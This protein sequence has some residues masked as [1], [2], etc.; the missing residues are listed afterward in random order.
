MSPERQVSRLQWKCAN[1]RTDSS[2]EHANDTAKMRMGT[3]SAIT[4]SDSEGAVSGMTQSSESMRPQ[5]RVPL[6]FFPQ[7]SAVLGIHNFGISNSNLWNSRFQALELRRASWGPSVPLNKSL[8]NTGFPPSTSR[9]QCRNHLM[10]TPL[11]LQAVN[12][13]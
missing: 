9:S 2:K 7:S 5:S 1:I 10:R 8:K 6:T 4:V 13:A 11:Q 12:L 3:T